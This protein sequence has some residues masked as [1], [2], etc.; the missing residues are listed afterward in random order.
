MPQ[1][2]LVEIELPNGWRTF[3]LPKAL[4]DRLKELLDRQDRTGKLTPRERREATALTELVDMLSLMK[5]RA[6]TAAGKRMA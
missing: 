5:A 1:T 2:V 4:D 6:Q 3:C